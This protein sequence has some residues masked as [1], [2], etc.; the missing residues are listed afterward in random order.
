[1]PKHYPRRFID[2]KIE[3]GKLYYK[4]LWK[5]YPD[6]E[7]TWEPFENIKHCTELLDLYNQEFSLEVQLEESVF[8][9]HAYG[10]VRISSQK[11]VNFDG[12]TSIDT[13]RTEIFN[14]CKNMGWNLRHIFQE[15]KSG[16]NIKKQS[17]IYEAIHIARYGSVLVFYDGSRFSRDMLGAL[18]LLENEI[19]QKNLGVYLIMENVFYQGAAGRMAFR[20]SLSAA[21]FHSE[22]TSDKI[23]ISIQ[24]RRATGHVIGPAPLGM[25]SV[26]INGIRKFEENPQEQRILQEIKDV[27]I[28]NLNKLAK[29]FNRKQ[30]LLR[31]KK[32]DVKRLQNIKRRFK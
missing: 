23:K 13:Q 22:L 29:K 30:I 1:M 21:A 26:F 12:H 15:C 17:A 31:N 11:Q 19:K 5:N 2:R 10:V 18:N 27:S 14:A 25:K 24:H 32:L 6:N 3:D 7:W 16:K 4:V 20:N 28:L 9:R 8:T